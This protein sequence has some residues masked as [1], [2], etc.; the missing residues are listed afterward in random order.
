MSTT[1]KNE[2]PF[3]RI[4]REIRAVIYDLLLDDSNNKQLF[5]GDIDSD[6]YALNRVRRNLFTI[7]W[8]NHYK[9]NRVRLRS[10]Y[11][12]RASDENMEHNPYK[13]TTSCCRNTLKLDLGV[14]VV[15]R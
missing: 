6:E 9:K 15:N 7:T 5:M 11:Y 8:P 12:A 14:M 3:L 13:E 4:P 10:R 1:T 2:P